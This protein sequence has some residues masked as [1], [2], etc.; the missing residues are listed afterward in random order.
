MHSIKM[1]NM[2][3]NEMAEAVNHVRRF[4]RQ[5]FRQAR[6][7]LS[8]SVCMINRLYRAHGLD[9]LQFADS[10]QGNPRDEIG[11]NENDQWP[12]K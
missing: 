3:P 12:G 2:E 11:A 10:K 1:T 7:V 9:W 8:F 4:W 6:I 5:M